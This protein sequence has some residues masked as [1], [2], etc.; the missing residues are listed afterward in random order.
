MPPHGHCS[1]RHSLQ[2]GM[3][4]HAVVEESQKCTFSIH[5]A[6][7]SAVHARCVNVINL[8]FFFA[9]Y[10]AIWHC[11][12]DDS[13][14][15]ACLTVHDAYKRFATSICLFCG[16]CGTHAGG[17]RRGRAQSPGSRITTSAGLATR[18]SL[19]LLFFLSKEKLLHGSAYTHGLGLLHGAYSL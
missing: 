8:F 2:Q 9:K 6:Y 4:L 11:L 12:L 14:F 15:F 3:H 10:I 18:R 17:P 7:R 5:D 19:P 1:R 16:K 13:S